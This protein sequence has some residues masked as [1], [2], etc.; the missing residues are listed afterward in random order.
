M[1][2]P[3]VDHLVALFQPANARHPPPGR[4]AI[5][6]HNHVI[7]CHEEL[8]AAD[9]VPSHEAQRTGDP[10]GLAQSQEAQFPGTRSC[11]PRPFCFYLPWL[12]HTCSGVVGCPG[13]LSRIAGEGSRGLPN[14]PKSGSVGTMIVVVT[15]LL[16]SFVCFFKLSPLDCKERKPVDPKRKSTRN[17]LLE[18]LKLKL[19]YFGHL[20]GRA[21][22][23]EKTLMLGKI[24]CMRRRGPQRMRRLEDIPT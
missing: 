2:S 9:D 4:G 21:H 24:E 12:C 14:T 20:M 10:E 3:P 15:I 17:I 16:R 22:S 5:Q 23:L 18:G 1:H 6:V 7:F 8:Q 11:G 13:M 19:Q